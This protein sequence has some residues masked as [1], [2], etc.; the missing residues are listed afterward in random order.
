MKE[1]GMWSAKEVKWELCYYPLNYHFQWN[2]EF[3]EVKNETRA[4]VFFMIA[5]VLG[6]VVFPQSHLPYARHCQ[7]WCHSH[8]NLFADNLCLLMVKCVSHPQTWEGT[9]K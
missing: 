2:M 7:S 5:E 4:D 6:V 1:S 8:T 9:H 3:I